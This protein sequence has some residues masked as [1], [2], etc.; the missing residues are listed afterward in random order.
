MCTL[1]GVHHCPLRQ[2]CKYIKLCL[3]QVQIYGTN[4]GL[5]LPSIRL[6]LHVNVTIVD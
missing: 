1:L 4:F 3:V 2:G 6:E 5:H